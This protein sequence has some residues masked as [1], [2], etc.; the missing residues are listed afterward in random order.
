MTRHRGENKQAQLACLALTEAANGR[1]ARAARGSRASGSV[2]PED[3]VA[4]LRGAASPQP[5]PPATYLLLKVA[6][7]GAFFPA[8]GCGGVSARPASSPPRGH[9]ALTARAPPLPPS[10]R[11][12]PGLSDHERAR[13]R[14]AR[15]V[16]ATG[17]GGGDCHVGPGVRRCWLGGGAR[18][19]SASRPL[20]PRRPT[21]SAVRNCRPAPS[22]RSPGPCTPGPAV[23]A[24]LKAWRWECK[25]ENRKGDG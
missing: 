20:R 7:R 6:A 3:R 23:R 14:D 24:P 18:L 16:R 2:S 13:D 17:E 4:G 9:R 1:R 5:P 21:V 22:A 19:R 25:T 12:A 8:A 15:P 10:L 11:F